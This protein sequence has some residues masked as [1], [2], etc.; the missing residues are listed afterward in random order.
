MQAVCHCVP[1]VQRERLHMGRYHVLWRLQSLPVVPRWED[2]AM[3]GNFAWIVVVM[4]GFC[5]GAKPKKIQ[6]KCYL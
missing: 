5:D 3:R 1:M 6:I 4:C 2:P